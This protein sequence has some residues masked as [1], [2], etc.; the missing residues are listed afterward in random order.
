MLPRRPQIQ[1]QERNQS[2]E[3]IL[4]GEKQSVKKPFPAVK[5][6]FDDLAKRGET[7]RQR[8]VSLNIPLE[9]VAK[10][11]GLSIGKASEIERGIAVPNEQYVLDFEKALRIEAARV[12]S[13]A[14]DVVLDK[15]DIA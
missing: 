3:E 10:R 9:Q 12:M 11:A 7:A 1:M 8:R 14:A 13:I 2:R 4:H 6:S 15:E 5:D